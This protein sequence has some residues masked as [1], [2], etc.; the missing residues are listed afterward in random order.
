M[1]KFFFLKGLASMVSDSSIFTNLAFLT[2]TKYLGSQPFLN[3]TVHDYLW[4][5]D[6]PLVKMANKIVSTKIPFS[7]FGLLDRVNFTNFFFKF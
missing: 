6:D 2:L 3:L 1:G 5:Y 4:G 7:K